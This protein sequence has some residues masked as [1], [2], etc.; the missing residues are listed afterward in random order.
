MNSL[1]NYFR[2]HARN[3]VETVGELRSQPIGTLLTILVIGI[4]LALPAALNV[5]VKNT[6]SL[7]GGWE[8]V[9]DFSLYLAPGSDAVQAANL[10][11]EI[12][13]LDLIIRVQ[14]ISPDE[15]LEDFRQGSGLGEVLVG[16]QNNPLPYTLIVRP[17]ESAAAAA[18]GELESRF[19][20][21]PA[22][23]LVRIDTEWV[24]RLN[25]ILDFLRRTVLI[26]AMLLVTAVV[27]VIGNTIRLDIQNR[28]DEI[29]VLKM[30]GA[31]DRFV[32]R[33]FLYIG[34]WYG[35]GGGVV[36]LILLGAGLQLLGGPVARLTGLYGSKL[37]LLGLD[38]GTALVV[39]A[40]GVLA[41][42]GGAWLAVAR[43]LKDIEP[44]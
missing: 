37:E 35:L 6:R 5:V 17:D 38:A 39:L 31:S 9:R 25:A 34:L 43:H 29:E 26:A 22:V 7:A 16:L 19:R 13:A 8:T 40:G 18:L 44:T 20:E 4:A 15:A 41:G 21:N 24:G 27:I 10:A 14:V 23:D 28:R 32:R 12:E 11:R 1:L 30:L 33:P 42:W 2:L 36:A 3:F